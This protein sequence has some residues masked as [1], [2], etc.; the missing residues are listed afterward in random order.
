MREVVGFRVINKLST[1][2]ITKGCK[3]VLDTI[4][5]LKKGSDDS[6]FIFWMESLEDQIEIT[7]ENLHKAEFARIK[8]ASQDN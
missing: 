5:E 8:D 6:D 3:E 4:D 2:R 7:L 1:E